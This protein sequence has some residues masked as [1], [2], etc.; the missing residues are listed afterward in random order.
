[1]IFKNLISACIAYM[2]AE[3]TSR[4]REFD[5]CERDLEYILEAISKDIENNTTIFTK[6]IANRFW[7]NGHRQIVSYEVEFAVYKF[8]L[9]QLKSVLEEEKFLKAENSINTLCRII[10]HG[11][12]LTDLGT[13]LAYDVLGAEHCQRNWDHSYKFPEEDLDALIKVATTMPTKQN[14]NYYKLIVST[15]LEFNKVVHRLARDLSNP[16]N[17]QRNSQVNANVLFIYVTNLIFSGSINQLADNH[18]NN[19][20]IA[21]GISSGG[22]ALAATQLDYRVGFCQCYLENELRNELRKKNINLH[23]QEH[24]KLLVGIGKP[25]LNLKWNQVVDSNN[26]IIDNVLPCTKSIQV[27]N[28]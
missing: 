24:I 12:E 23:D 25:N 5:K 13:T 19:T 7:Y 27:F 17:P 1:M 16:Y 9:E 18:D 14:R 2:K 28:I 15:D 6:R 8:L 11:P 10:E 21:V 22:L 26:K 3:Y 20:T 4:T